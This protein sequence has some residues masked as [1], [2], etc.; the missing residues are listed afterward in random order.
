MTT[1]AAVSD[2][3]PPAVRHT[4]I[5]IGVVTLLGASDI[6]TSLEAP[7]S[8][9]VITAE[10]IPTMHPTVCEKRMGMSCLRIT[11]SC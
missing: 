3:I 5:A 4:S 10:T 11:L 2:G 8:C 7:K 1:M 6:T 9:A